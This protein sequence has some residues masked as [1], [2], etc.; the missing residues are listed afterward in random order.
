VAT[1][2]TRLVTAPP[3]LPRLCAETAAQCR[4]S[5]EAD[6]Y[7]SHPDR[8]FGRGRDTRFDACGAR[9]LVGVQPP[10][11]DSIGRTRCLLNPSAH[12]GRRR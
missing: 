6:A 10:N 1:P 12:D 7:A 3:L 2:R 5:D 11:S 4:E 8:T 9:N